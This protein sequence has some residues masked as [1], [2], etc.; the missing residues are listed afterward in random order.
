[1]KLQ[2]PVSYRHLLIHSSL[3]NL[4]HFPLEKEPVKE[5]K[6][7]GEETPAD[8]VMDDQVSDE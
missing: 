6:R 5:K 1:M 7:D 4:T 8:Q 2:L 3:L